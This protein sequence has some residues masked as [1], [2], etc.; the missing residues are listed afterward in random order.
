[1]KKELILTAIF[2]IFISIIAMTGI[3]YVFSWDEPTGNM[4][5]DYDGMALIN[6]GESDQYKAGVI[7]AQ[8]FRDNDDNN[9]YTKPIWTKCG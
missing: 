3:A 5:G 4:P 9:F 6:T 8:E 2:S 1:M 7:G